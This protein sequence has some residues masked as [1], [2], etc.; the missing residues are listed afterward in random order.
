MLTVQVWAWGGSGIPSLLDFT[1][2]VNERLVPQGDFPPGR[3]IPWHLLGLGQGCASHTA[4]LKG[5][6]SIY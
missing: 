5:F 1:G 4:L 2:R 6:K 3:G